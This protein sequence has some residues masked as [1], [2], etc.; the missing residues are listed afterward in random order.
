M[1]EW[2][3]CWS[4][5]YLS[6]NKIWDDLGNGKE[7]VVNYLFIGPLQIRWYSND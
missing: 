3:I 6:Y 5:W 4:R 7:I 1:I 2:Q